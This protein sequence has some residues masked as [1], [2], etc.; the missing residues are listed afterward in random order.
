MDVWSCLVVLTIGL[1]PCVAFRV[2]GLVQR[3]PIRVSLEV[4]GGVDQFLAVWPIKATSTKSSNQCF[5]QPSLPLFF[6]CAKQCNQQDLNREEDGWK[7]NRM[8][9]CRDLGK[10][11][12]R[13]A[14][15][16]VYAKARWE[17]RG[18]R[19][20][21][22]RQRKCGVQRWEEVQR[23]GMWWVSVY[24][25]QTHRTLWLCASAT[26]RLWWV[27]TANQKSRRN[28]HHLNS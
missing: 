14:P 9:R 13:K 19:E 8:E 7:E 15:V 26:Q 6:C 25:P 27:T 18:E 24:G 2:V 1:L 28:L 23:G 21:G 10:N 11:Q 3:E 17:G 20:K 12:N 5:P 22:S 4:A 16:F